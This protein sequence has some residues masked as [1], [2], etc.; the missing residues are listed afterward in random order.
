MAPSPL[1]LDTSSLISLIVQETDLDRV[2]SRSPT[3]STDGRSLPQDELDLIPSPL[4]HYSRRPSD[5]SLPTAT[6]DTLWTIID[7]IKDIDAFLDEWHILQLS[8]IL[9][10][11]KN[12]S[13]RN[14]NCRRQVRSSV[15]S[16]EEQRIR[17]T[18]DNYRVSDSY[19][20]TSDEHSP[21]SSTCSS[22]VSPRTRPEA[23]TMP[24]LR[25]KKAAD[26]L[27]DAFR[28]DAQTRLPDRVEIMEPLP[29]EAFVQI[30]P[31]GG[32]YSFNFWV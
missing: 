32:L 25:R 16:F 20:T 7:L 19:R 15:D 10:A 28:L 21:S 4:F 2:H 27:R 17:D 26:N 24:P 1:C 18:L 8:F 22:P 23:K 3:H 29:E 11:M 9:M 6:A 5:E 30:S 12:K 13:Y 31:G 14:R